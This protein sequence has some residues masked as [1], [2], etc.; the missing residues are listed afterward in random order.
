MRFR[1]KDD[2][3]IR[4]RYFRG[5]T[6][7]KIWIPDSVKRRLGLE[8]IV[9]RVEVDKGKVRIIIEKEVDK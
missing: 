2:I 3:V 6:T 1:A 4:S 9:P 8:E 5:K 7:V